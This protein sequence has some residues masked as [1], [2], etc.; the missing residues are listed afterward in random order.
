MVMMCLHT[1]FHTPSFNVSLV[2]AIKP[3]TNRLHL[4]TGCFTEVKGKVAP[5]LN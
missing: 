2:I 5:V 1:K 3:E 4:A